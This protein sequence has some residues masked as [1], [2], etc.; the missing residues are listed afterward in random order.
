MK[1]YEQIRV[2]I[3][4]RVYPLVALRWGGSITAGIPK[5]VVN[6]ATS[7]LAGEASLM[8]GANQT[9]RPAPDMF[10]GI[11]PGNRIYLEVFVDDKMVSST[12]FLLTD[13]TFTKADVK[14]E[15]ST[16]TLAFSNPI[17]IAPVGEY[18][19]QGWGRGD[20]DNSQR[21]ASSLGAVSPG[22][23]PGWVVFQAMR[24]AGFHCVPMYD[25]ATTMVDLPCQWTTITE[26]WSMNGGHTITAFADG[27]LYGKTT[28]VYRDGMTWLSS[29]QLWVGTTVE[30]RRD[31]GTPR[32]ISG[33]FMW[34]AG[35]SGGG[36]FTI[37]TG[38]GNW[39]SFNPGADRSLRVWTSNGETGSF[40]AGSIPSDGVVQ[41]SVST[42]QNR[43]RCKIGQ[44][45]RSGA[46]YAT[47]NPDNMDTRDTWFTGLKVVAH[48]GSRFAGCQVRTGYLESG[49]YLD[50]VL[51]PAGIFTRTAHI[52][53]P[54]SGL[55]SR[56]TPSVRDELARDVLNELADALC[57]SWWVDESGVCR[58]RDMQSLQQGPTV[59]TLAIDK[60]VADYQLSGEDTVNRD[61][62]EVQYSNVAYSRNQ[63]A[64]VRVYEGRGATISLD[65]ENEEL[66]TPKENE[67]WLAV[68]W[69]LGWYNKWAEPRRDTSVNSWVSTTVKAGA[70]STRQSMTYVNPWTYIYKAW[71]HTDANAE[72]SAQYEVDGQ[73]FPLIQA[74]GLMQYTPISKR[75]GSSSAKAPFVHNG[76]RW[77]TTETV[78][79]NIGNWLLGLSRN[80]VPMRSLSI[81]YTP[82]LR[83]GDVIVLTDGEASF[84]SRRLQVTQISHEPDK[85]K[86][87]L[88]VVEISS[89]D[90][91][92]LTWGVAEANAR[93]DGDS[94]LYRNIEASRAG[95]EPTW[96]VV[97][98]NHADYPYG[99]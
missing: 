56:A 52:D 34:G 49:H 18:M 38:G 94:A 28:L 76:G 1:T 32:E 4:N 27:D 40:P 44:A 59:A 97:E 82:K 96:E 62:V 12:P 2:H 13:V 69:T 46:Y 66:I 78:A 57:A 5:A 22:A 37:I 3:N 50:G 71:A 51:S 43:W 75:Y 6:T 24:A 92:L 10:P 11:T 33:H 55:S 54:L 90:H 8:L 16:N 83:L 85:M 20:G 68:D 19:P 99:V 36:E 25:H 48:D 87:D 95:N 89:S 67:E 35:A 64:R 88:Q 65:D 26:A 93:R 9:R 45:E 47:I 23:S 77:V 58:F 17:R 63:L 72:F 53:I 81:I 91:P 7:A 60:D 39:V 84:T 70:G 80:P 98:T 31:W 30:G 73:K 29:G 74:R 42:S 86:T 15:F 79:N 14:V 61:A 21:W 41:V